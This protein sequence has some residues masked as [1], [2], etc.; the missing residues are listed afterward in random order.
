M[1]EDQHRTVAIVGTGW[2]GLAL[3]AALAT[4]SNYTVR[5]SYRESGGTR[6]EQVEAS[7]A[8]PYLVDLPERT[9][10]IIDFFEGVDTVVLTIPPGGRKYG[11]AAES[12][13]L[14]LLRTLEP[15]LRP[16]P[17]IYTSSTGVYG[18]KARGRV[19][20][21]NPVQPDTH[22]TKA[23]VAAEDY[24]R[25]NV[26]RLTVLR[27]AGLIGP[28]RNPAN[29]FRPGGKGLKR[30]QA[31]VNLVHREDVVQAIR[32]AIEQERFGTYNVCAAHHPSRA[33]YYGPKLL[34]AGW[35]EVSFSEEGGEEKQVDSS[36]IRRELGW[37]P[38]H[39]RL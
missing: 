37:Q 26:T 12:R 5:A 35:E 22:S 17:L 31:P 39:D 24:L 34:A 16:R 18:R 29:F 21:R 27:L 28:D 4:R 14:G 32:L 10:R 30:G 23:V 8:M 9:E 7:G 6:P 13:Y 33:A 2:L 15:F 25:E 1:K 19:D 20:E 36:K 3:A 38:V 11:A